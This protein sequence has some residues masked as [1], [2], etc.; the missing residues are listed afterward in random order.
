[1]NGP[2]ERTVVVDL[3]IPFWRLVMFFI[4]SAFASLA[5]LA[6]VGAVLIAVLGSLFVGFLQVIGVP[7]PE[8][9][10]PPTP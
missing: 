9:P 3:R 7:V 2:V 6:V 1:M 8:L 4:K 5:A 10:N